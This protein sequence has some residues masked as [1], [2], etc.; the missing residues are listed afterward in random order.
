MD[1]GATAMQTN[2]VL[3]GIGAAFAIL[4][5]IGFSCSLLFL[6]M[7]YGRYAA[8]SSPPNEGGPPPKAESSSKSNASNEKS[9][10]TPDVSVAV[11]NLASGESSTPSASN[12]PVVTPAKPSVDK[13]NSSTDSTTGNAGDAT[14]PTGGTSPSV[15]PSP[16]ST[17]PGVGSSVLPESAPPSTSWGSPVGSGNWYPPIGNGS[18]PV[19]PPASSFPGPGAPG[20]GPSWDLWIWVWNLPS[21][22]LP[23]VPPAGKP[24]QIKSVEA[25]SGWKYNDSYAVEWSVT[26]DESRIQRYIVSLIVTRPEK[27]QPYYAQVFKATNVKPGTR[28]LV[29]KL[30]TVSASQPFYYVSPVVIAVPKTRRRPRTNASVRPARSF[31]HSRPVAARPHPFLHRR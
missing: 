1:K 13:S 8:K 27:K 16:G 19:M 4:T 18:W 2:K 11:T 23:I 21:W 15:S 6:G 31:Q 9:K 26:G 14:L 12:Q 22:K 24:F 30:N 29:C 17:V 25:T 7:T 5:M 10:E 28:K 3:F 20:W